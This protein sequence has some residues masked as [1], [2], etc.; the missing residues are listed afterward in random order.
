MQPIATDIVVWTCNCRSRLWAMEKR[1][2]CSRR[3]LEGRLGRVTKS[4]TR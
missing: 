4:C 3:Q 2:N 1:L